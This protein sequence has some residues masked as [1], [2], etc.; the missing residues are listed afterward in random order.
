MTV[1]RKRRRAIVETTCRG[2]RIQAVATAVGLVQ[3]VGTQQEEEEE[4][5]GVES[6]K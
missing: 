2:G 4:G 6:Q 3:S 1:L 5:E